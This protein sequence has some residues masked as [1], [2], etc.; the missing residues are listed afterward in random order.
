MQYRPRRGGLDLD[1]MQDVHKALDNLLTE[2]AV[3]S[4]LLCDGLS[5]SSL[6][7]QP[8]AVAIEADLARPAIPAAMELLRG[9]CTAAGLWLECAGCA[10]H[11]QVEALREHAA[12]VQ[13]VSRL[14]AHDARQAARRMPPAALF[15][16]P[17]ATP[18][19]LQASRPAAVP[20]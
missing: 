15:V 13:T 6:D 12:A 16:L 4:E 2:V 10:L 9:L 7:R 1:R 14:L 5:A 11:K 17:L 3:G 8:L 19:S 18:R 20:R